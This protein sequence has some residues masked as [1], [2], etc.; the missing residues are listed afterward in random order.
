MPL[1]QKA[2][3]VDPGFGLSQRQEPRCDEVEQSL[4]GSIFSN[5]G[6]PL[7]L[8]SSFLRA[9]H[10]YVTGHQQLYA[11]LLQEKQD[12]N[13]IDLK[14]VWTKVRG[15][16][17]L[18]GLGDDYLRVLFAACRIDNAI[19]MVPYARA[20]IQCWKRR[21]G[22]AALGRALD[23]LFGTDPNL[24]A[25]TVLGRA[26][27]EQIGIIGEGSERKSVVAGDA[28]RQAIDDV[29]A[30]RRGETDCGLPFGLAPVE[31][32][33]GLLR[34]GWLYILGGRPGSGKTSLAAQMMLGVA[35]FLRDEPDQLF[36]LPSCVAFFSLEMPDEQVGGWMGCNVGDIP[37]EILDGDRD[38]TAAEAERVIL[39]QKELDTLPIQ[40]INGGGKPM[41]IEDIVTRALA[42]TRTHRVRLVVIDHAQRIKKNG[43][44][45]TAETQ[46]ITA[47]LKDLAR[48]LNVPVLALAQL[49][50]E[51]DK[52]ENPKP[53]MSDLMWGGEADADV[54]FMLHRPGD[55]LPELPTEPNPN[56]NDQQFAKRRDKWYRERDKWKDRVELIVGKRRQGKAKPST[57]L[58]FKGDNTSFYEVG[59]PVA[60]NIGPEDADGLPF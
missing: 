30:I 7:L 10:F 26:I 22:I 21:E 18:E 54:V 33:I 43:K 45:Q 27:D 50:K 32:A 46:K 3:F 49:T 37:N 60:S 48:R 12:G 19:T 31:K 20:I 28:F 36:K 58:G 52:R 25:E 53:R 11:F 40:L 13:P 17:I 51:S 47:M 41:T 6:R 42:M 4:L 29:G 23:G 39:A 9:E 38:I 16:S 5:D 55:N 34:P 57:V 1:E 59:T 24:D 56:E 15:S 44:D 14:T 2:A 8:V 35:R